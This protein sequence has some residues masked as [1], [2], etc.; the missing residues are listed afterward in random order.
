MLISHKSIKLK[1]NAS[2]VFKILKE[3]SNK[4]EKEVSAYLK[5]IQSNKDL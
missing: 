5:L 2:G 4:C 3:S 1:N